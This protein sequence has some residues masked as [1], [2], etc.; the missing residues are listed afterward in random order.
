MATGAAACHASPVGAGD[1]IAAIVLARIAFFPDHALES[2]AA[3]VGAATAFLVPNLI[4]LSL[5]GMGDVKLALLLGA[6]LGWASSPQ[7][8]SRS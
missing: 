8:A 2:L 7:S 5:M 4:G 6:G 1:A 3:A